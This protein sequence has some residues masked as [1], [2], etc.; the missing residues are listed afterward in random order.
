MAVN[1]TSMKENTQKLDKIIK[2]YE[3]KNKRKITKCE[4]NVVYFYSKYMREKDR[5]LKK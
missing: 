4:R 2:Q 5:G 3:A 1:K